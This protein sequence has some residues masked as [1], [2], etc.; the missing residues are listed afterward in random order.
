ME[1]AMFRIAIVQPV[2]HSPDLAEAN[3][4]DAVDHVA[5]RLRRH[6]A[7]VEIRAEWR[8][9]LGERDRVAD[10]RLDAVKRRQ[11]AAGCAASE[12]LRDVAL[13]L[14]HWH[15]PP[16]HKGNGFASVTAIREQS[17]GGIDP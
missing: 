17:F 1:R 14:E 9:L 4:S 12:A 15:F 10:K 16:S 8:P 13:R 11:R 2:A 3:V 5:Q 6:D 7:T